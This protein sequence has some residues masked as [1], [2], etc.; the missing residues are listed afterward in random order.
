MK[1]VQLPLNPKKKGARELF[2]LPQF[3]TSDE[4]TGKLG[5]EKG[6]SGTNNQGGGGGVL[7]GKGKGKNHEQKIGVNSGYK[8][9]QQTTAPVKKEGRGPPVEKSHKTQVLKR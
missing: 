1:M 3:A 8:S 7:L 4:T 5:G 6:E 2:C 9:G